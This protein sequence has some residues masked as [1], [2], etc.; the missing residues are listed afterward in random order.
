MPAATV[1]KSSLSP[2]FQSISEMLAAM[3]LINVKLVRMKLPLRLLIV[4]VV[5][6]MFARTAYSAICK[7]QSASSMISLGRNLAPLGRR[8]YTVL[9]TNAKQII[10]KCP[11]RLPISILNMAQSREPRE[12]LRSSEKLQKEKLR[13]KLLVVIT[14]VV[15]FEMTVFISTR[16]L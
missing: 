9:V 7:V 15:M 14:A 16:R 3:P 8:R 11:K 13:A 10:T 6:A 2:I 5:E 4:S 1:R 12:R